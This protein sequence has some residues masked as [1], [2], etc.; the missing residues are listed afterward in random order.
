MRQR[1]FAIPASIILC[2]LLVVTSCKKDPCETEICLP[3]PSSRLVF[4]YVD[5]TGNCLPAFHASAR[6]YAIS[7]KTSDTLYTYTFSDSCQ[8]GFIV[9]DSVTYHLVG[10]SPAVHDIIAIDSIAYQ[11]PISVT[12]CCLCYPAK[13]IKG[14]LNGVPLDVAFKLG[15]Y[16]NEPYVRDLN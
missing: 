10:S 15:D 16:V 11:D 7:N 9:A 14:T 13:Y 1:L 8:V 4:Q 6:V 2:L 5:S 12:E 3:C